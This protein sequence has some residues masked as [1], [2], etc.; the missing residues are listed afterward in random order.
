VKDP[1]G[2]IFVTSS[3]SPPFKAKLSR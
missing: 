2:E 3:H 1:L